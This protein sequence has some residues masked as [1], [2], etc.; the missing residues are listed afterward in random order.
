MFCWLNVDIVLPWKPWQWRRI[1][2]SKHR[3]WSV[4]VWL[5]VRLYFY[6]EAAGKFWTRKIRIGPLRHPRRCD[7]SSAVNRRTNWGCCRGCIHRSK[8]SQLRYCLETAFL[9]ANSSTKVVQYKWAKIA[10]SITDK[11]LRANNLE[12]SHSLLVV[13][14]RSLQPTMMICFGWKVGRWFDHGSTWAGTDGFWFHNQRR[15]CRRSGR[16]RVGEEAQTRTGARVGRNRVAGT[17][18][19]LLLLL[20]TASRMVGLALQCWT[21]CHT[22]ERRTSR[23]DGQIVNRPR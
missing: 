13:V 11:R 15:R 18:D 16:V 10:A 6:R 12:A 4:R 19:S 7:W 9:T 21:K 5:L 8:A 3:C 2:L 14:P 22:A 1:S 17:D 23:W 20:E